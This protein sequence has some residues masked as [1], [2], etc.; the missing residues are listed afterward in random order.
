MYT[1]Y[2]IILAIFFLSATFLFWNI[3]HTTRAP[4]DAIVN[5]YVRVLLDFVALS[6]I[7]LLVGGLILWLVPDIKAIA[8]QPPTFEWIDAL[9]ISI[10]GLSSFGFIAFGFYYKK[11]GV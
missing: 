6:F 7:M 9:I 4:E 2:I 3:I 1:V 10:L 8:N 11:E 5:K